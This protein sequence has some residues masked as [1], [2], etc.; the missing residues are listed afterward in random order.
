MYRTPAAQPLT[1][2]LF[3]LRP[4]LHPAPQTAALFPDLQEDAKHSYGNFMLSSQITKSAYPELV[5]Y[6]KTS[7]LHH[8]LYQPCCIALP[9]RTI[10]P[11]FILFA[12]ISILLS[13]KKGASVEP[14][15]VTVPTSICNLIAIGITPTCVGKRLRHF[16]HCRESQD[17][18]HACGEKGPHQRNRPQKVGSPPR[19]WGKA[20]LCERRVYKW[21]NW[22][23]TFNSARLRFRWFRKWATKKHCIMQCLSALVVA[24]IKNNL[25]FQSPPSLQGAIAGIENILRSH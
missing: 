10:E 8:W 20:E 4:A 16:L 23:C 6:Y 3:V 18:P 11:S 9:I 25:A 12:G 21:K 1:S 19:V 2:L 24:V 5:T 17:H 22:K 7:Y 13:K 15:P 14:P